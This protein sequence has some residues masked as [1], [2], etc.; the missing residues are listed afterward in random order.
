MPQAAQL[1]EMLRQLC[2]AQEDAAVSV[3]F[4]DWQVRRYQDKAYVLAALGE[5]DSNLVLPWRGEAQL[6]WPALNRPLFFAQM[7][8]QGIALEKLRR[9]PVSL[10]LRNG[11]ET[12]RP[13]PRAA[14]RSLKNLLQEH[15]VPPW[16][17][18][19]L[20]LLYCGDELVCVAGVAIA[21]DYRAQKD[22][23]GLCVD[24]A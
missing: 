2:G 7:P 24:A 23:E 19:R 18:E 10:R 16:L 15:H 14:N 20:P 17:R 5:F 13:H 22:E 1:D 3:G 6:F 4:G 9:A 21:A 8:G 12:L 11:G